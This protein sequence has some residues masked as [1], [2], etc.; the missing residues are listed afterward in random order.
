MGRGIHLHEALETSQ[1]DAE[2]FA[3]AHYPSFGSCLDN[4]TLNDVRQGLPSRR[5]MSHSFMDVTAFGSD[6]NWLTWAKSNPLMVLGLASPIFSLAAA[7]LTGA[8]GMFAVAAASPEPAA[9]EAAEDGEGLFGDFDFDW[10][11]ED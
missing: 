3:L 5:V 10:G 9:E 2:Q 4:V 6:D 7:A 1:L 11:D 8:A